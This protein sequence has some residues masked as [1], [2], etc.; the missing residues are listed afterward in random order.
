MRVVQVIE[1]EREL[2]SKACCGSNVLSHS[3]LIEINMI[4]L[5]IEVGESKR[6]EAYEDDYEPRLIPMIL[7]M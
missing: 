7:E 5:D 4:R 2:M 3:D 1:L 6:A